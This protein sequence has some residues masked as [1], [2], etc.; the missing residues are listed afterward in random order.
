MAH[1]TFEGK[2]G[3]SGEHA[4]VLSEKDLEMARE[5]VKRAAKF[6]KRSEPKDPMTKNLIRRNYFQVRNAQRV[7]AVTRWN[8]RN[9]ENQTREGELGGGTGWAVAMA[10]ELKCP[11][12]YLYAMEKAQW[13]SWQLDSGSWE[14]VQSV[15]KPHGRYAGIGSR[16]LKERGDPK[17]GE[18]IIASLYM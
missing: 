14:T 17:F 6:L 4:R 18:K 7:Y 13:Y 1:F 15:P 2:G 5:P 3:Y 10:I 11:E 12:I 16:D 9:G 8:L